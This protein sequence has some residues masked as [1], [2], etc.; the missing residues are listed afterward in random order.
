MKIAKY[1]YAAQ[2][3]HL[4]RV[5]RAIDDLLVRGDYVLGPH[6]EQFE[7]DFADYIGV[8]HAVGVNSGTDALVLALRALG[9]GPGDE[10]VTVANTFHA[11]VLAITTVGARP[12]LVDCTPHDYLM[13]LEQV[14]AAITGRTRAIIAVHLFGKALDMAAVTAIAERHGLAVVEDCAQAVGASW[15]GRRVGSWGDIGCFSFH[16]SKN[17]AAAGDAG[18]VTTD[19]ADLARTI[20]TLRGLGQAA[21]NDHVALGC[22][23][24]LDAIQAI[25]LS[26]K[27]PELDGWNAGRR[28]VAGRYSRALAGI[29]RVPEPAGREH[30]FHLYQVGV[31]QRDEVLAE[32][33]GA[34]I[35]AVVRY[36]VPIHRQ[37]AFAHLDLPSRFPHAD[38]QAAHTLCL[39]VRPDLTGT[40]IDY[41]VDQVTSAVAK[42]TGA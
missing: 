19:R 22:N 29:A 30:V 1:H 33:V 27:L 40:E 32:L 9:V 8:E 35:D 39:P 14:E 26:H 4:P 7:Q 38:W 41:I 24:K 23:S 3:R 6:V 34:G 18:A 20:R 2:F 17:L 37:P 28:A 42:R 31:E 36:P 16:P 11:T 13:D 12:V 25:V 15:Q 21:Q 5:V 10:V